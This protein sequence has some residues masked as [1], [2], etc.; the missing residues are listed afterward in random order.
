MGRL[1]PEDFG[2]KDTLVF[3]GGV[4]FGSVVTT[5]T[6]DRGNCFQINN[7]AEI[8][9]STPLAEFYVGHYHQSSNWAGNT[10]YFRWMAGANILGDGFSS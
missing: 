8:D 7:A 1:I 5:P 6:Q 2:A 3:N 4:T 10:G 9:L